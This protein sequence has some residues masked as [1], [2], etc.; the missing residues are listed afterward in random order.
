MN[1]PGIDGM[2]VNSVTSPPRGAVS[3]MALAFFIVAMVAMFATQRDYGVVSDVS[4]YFFNSIRQLAWFEDLWQALLDG[5]PSAALNRESVLEHWRVDPAR[6]PHPPLSREISGLSWLLF[7]DV[8][9]TVGAYRV[10][11]MLA[12][13]ALTAACAT[14]TANSSGSITA[15]VGAGLTVLTMPVLFAHGHFAHTD[16]FLAAFWFAS[17]SCL[18]RWVEDSRPAMLFTA[19]LLLG[20]ALATKF[21]GLLLAPVLGL[22]LVL[23][24]P[25]DAAWAILILAVCA[26]AVFFLSNPVLWV[27]PKLGIADYFGAGLERAEGIGGRIQTQYFGQFYT[28]RGPWHYPFVWTAIV[29]PPTLLLSIVAGL[30]DRR[31]WGVIGFCLLNAAVLYAALLMPSAPMHDGVRLFLAAFPFFAVLSGIG[32][33]FLADRLGQ[34]L[35]S[36][37]RPKMPLVT[38]VVLLALFLPAAGAVVRTHPYQLSYFNLLIGGIH[39]AAEKGLEVTN[40]KEVLNDEALEDLSALIPDDAVLDAGFLFEEICFYQN[41]DR[42]PRGWSVE[43]EWPRSDPVG[44][45]LNLICAGDPVR[46]PAA[47]DRPSGTPDFLLVLNRKAMWRPMELAINGQN[48]QPYY[49][50]KLDGVPLLSLYRLQ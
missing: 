1:P 25:R 41:L 38:A 27:D 29:I 46:A 33:A 32:V 18:Y 48:A 6:I 14:F 3:A 20:A 5:Q 22:W 12:Y 23:R 37:Y 17:A 44:S 36:N 9:D 39:G 16:L 19:G 30:F 15:G 31:R 49:Q 50:V 21:T 8:F 4:N 45:K 34:L 47:V 42:A 2:K 26:A 11:V 7:R 43:V 13:A 35:P 40:L 10:G 24:R 28:Y